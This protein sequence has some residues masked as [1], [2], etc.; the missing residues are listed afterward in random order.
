MSL[1]DNIKKKKI[2]MRGSKYQ[3][4]DLMK[5]RNQNQ[6][7]RK[8]PHVYHCFLYVFKRTIKKRGIFNWHNRKGHP[9]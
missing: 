7:L 8:F 2:Q 3:G 5:R 6:M 4:L 9:T 1:K